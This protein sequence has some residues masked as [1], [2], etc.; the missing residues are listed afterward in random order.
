MKPEPEIRQ[1]IAAVTKDSFHVLDCY[2][3]TVQINA[4]RALM[5]VIAKTELDTLY[6]ALG[7]KRPQFKCD[8]RTK[9]DW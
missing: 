1:R 6:W 9:M 4:P 3:A 8:D 7:E 5:Q 2:P